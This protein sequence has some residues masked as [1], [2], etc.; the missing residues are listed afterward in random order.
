MIQINLLPVREARRKEDLRQ[1][2]LHLVFVLLIVGSGVGYAHSYVTE[3][4]DTAELRVRQMQSDIAKFKPQLDQVAAFREKKA[5]LQKKIDIIAG[6]DRARRG[7][8]RV[9][10][11]LATHTPERLWLDSV[12]TDG[13][14]IELTGQSL[15]NELVAVFLGALGDSP[16]FE[17]VDLDSTEL[18]SAGDGLKVV[19]FRIQASMV[20]PQEAAPEQSEG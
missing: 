9:M 11:E 6:L 5:E 12:A 17:N 3:R 4:I 8:V 16:Y 2:A 7:P 18:G 20:A 19:K 14:E 13:T 10:D 1:H 15:D